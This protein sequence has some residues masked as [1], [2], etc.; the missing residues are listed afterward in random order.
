MG[1]ISDHLKQSNLN[2][3]K[4]SMEASMI[5]DSHSTQ[6]ELKEKIYPRNI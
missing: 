6:E 2:I 4:E 1:A 5:K 3:I